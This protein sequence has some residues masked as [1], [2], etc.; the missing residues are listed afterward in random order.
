MKK[1]IILFI[2][3]VIVLCAGFIGYFTLRPI[4]PVSKQEKTLALEKLL[5]RN[6][7]SQA[8]VPTVNGTYQGT[9]VTFTYP[10]GSTAYTS[11]AFN[12]GP[13]NLEHFQ[14]QNHSSHLFFAVSVD[15]ANEDSLS[16]VSGVALRQSQSAVY[17]Q[18]QG[19]IDGFPALIFTSQQDDYEKT[20]FVLHLGRLYTFSA[21]GPEE[22]AVDASFA[23]VTSSVKFLQ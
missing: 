18:T 16:Q 9:Y 12:P 2:L 7:I 4:Q 5:G 10:P 1:A 21:S 19:T 8:D 14:F 3:I 13:L 11:S 22:Q 23:Q 17:T 20:A 6:L 15:T